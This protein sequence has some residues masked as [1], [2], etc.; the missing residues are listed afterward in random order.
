ME[1]TAVP[2]RDDVRLGRTIGA[3][4]SGVDPRHLRP[5]DR[6]PCRSGSS[7]FR[8]IA[9]AVTKMGNQS[10]YPQQRP[11]RIGG[12]RRSCDRRCTAARFQGPTIPATPRPQAEAAPRLIVVRPA[13]AMA[14]VR[15]DREK[16]RLSQ[17]PLADRALDHLKASALRRR[18]AMEAVEPATSPVMENGQA[19]NR[20]PPSPFGSQRKSRIEPDPRLSARVG[21][22]R[23]QRELFPC[24]T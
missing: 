19:G 12:D 10:R 7:P 13:Q 17:T 24:A 22:N 3:V 20:P 16:D 8:N 4:G 9:R 23:R 2:E 18:E 11:V 6:R 1:R 21:A 15:P 5:G 14:H